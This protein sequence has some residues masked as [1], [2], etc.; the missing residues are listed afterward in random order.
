MSILRPTERP[1]PGWIPAADR[2]LAVN[3]QR[4]FNERA[5]TLVDD[6]PAALDVLVR[7]ARA[8]RFDCQ[9]AGSA[10]QAVELLE[11]KLTPLVVTDLRM[12]GR[13]GLWLVQEV[14]KRWPEVAVIVV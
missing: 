12:P 1:L 5:V 13:G 4:L 14:H 10:E 9:A 6:E 2:G 3:A 7:A 8:F 11:K